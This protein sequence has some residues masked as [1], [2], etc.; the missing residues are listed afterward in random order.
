MS[1]ES[2]ETHFSGYRVNRPSGLVPACSSLGNSR[3]GASLVHVFPVM[4]FILDPKRPLCLSVFPVLLRNQVVRQGQALR[5]QWVRPKISRHALN[6]QFGK[7]LLWV[8]R[9]NYIFFMQFRKS[10]ED[11]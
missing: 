2:T 11:A 8:L 3:A 4:D 7:L 6:G 1:N 9:V 10:L 5:W